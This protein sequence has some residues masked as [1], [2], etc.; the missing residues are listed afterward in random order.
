M[1]KESSKLIRLTSA[2]RMIT[3]K[4]QSL[5]KPIRHL[6]MSTRIGN[7]ANYDAGFLVRRERWLH[8]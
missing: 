4:E 2:T 1:K 7:R 5:H 3:G 6:E 8:R